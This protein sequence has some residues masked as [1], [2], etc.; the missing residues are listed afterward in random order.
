MQVASQLAASGF[1]DCLLQA[2]HGLDDAALRKFLVK[3]QCSLRTELEENPNGHLKCHHVSLA[4][5]I[6]ESFP[7]I[8]VL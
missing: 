7:K 5:K 3:W 6:P 8:S 4:H 1:G 2:V